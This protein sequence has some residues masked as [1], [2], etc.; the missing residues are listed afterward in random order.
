MVLKS[1]SLSIGLPHSGHSGGVSGKVS[2]SMVFSTSTN[3]TSATMPATSSQAR[4][5]AAPMAD[6]AFCAGVFRL[7]QRAAGRREIVKAVGLLVALAVEI[8]APALVG[9]AS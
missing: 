3:G 1:A 7:D 9:A 4:L 5:A 8:P 2:S 6:D